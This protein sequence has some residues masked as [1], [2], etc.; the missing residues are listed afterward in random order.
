VGN[1]PPALPRG[2]PDGALGSLM[3]QVWGTPRRGGRWWLGADVCAWVGRVCPECATAT[4]GPRE[5]LVVEGG[6]WVAGP[7]H[8]R[9]C[10]RP[11]VLERVRQLLC[12][13]LPVP[14]AL[15]DPRRCGVRGSRFG[16]HWGLMGPANKPVCPP[17]PS[18]LTPLAPVVAP[19]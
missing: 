3:C 5:E 8:L 1:P 14:L 11:L 6:P 9:P 18:P 19:V 7:L 13:A 2:A 12:W 10:P 16:R 17:L 4:E 15:R